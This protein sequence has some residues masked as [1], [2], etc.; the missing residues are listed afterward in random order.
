MS[1][2]SGTA[3]VVKKGSDSDK[4]RSDRKSR[5]Q[6]GGKGLALE[7]KQSEISKKG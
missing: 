4:E 7:Q 1:F 5:S 3:V 6:R 2:S